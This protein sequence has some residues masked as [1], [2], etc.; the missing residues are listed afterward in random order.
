MK[1]LMPLIALLCS[2]T[3][4]AQSLSSSSRDDVALS[5]NP[6]SDIALNAMDD[7]FKVINGQAIDVSAPGVLAND[8]GE[9]LTSVL[10]QP[11]PE[12]DP[13]YQPLGSLTLFKDGGLHYEPLPGFVGVDTFI[14][15]ITDADGNNSKA[16]IS[17]YCFSE[18]MDVPIFAANDDEFKVL[19]CGAIEVSA[20]GVL[21]NDIGS[22]L[23]VALMDPTQYGEDVVAPQGTL[24]LN[25]DGSF[26]YA[27][28]AGF[29]GVDTFYLIV[30]DEAGNAAKSMVSFYCFTEGS[31]ILAADP[32]SMGEPAGDD[33]G[34]CSAAA[35]AAPWMLLPMIGLALMKLRRARA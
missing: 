24:T 9:N 32:Q 8:S 29:E 30:T 35:G 2:A 33:A 16:A 28:L 5:A 10:Y 4:T 3:I 18:S 7:D 11:A 22:G 20:P 1:Y 13:D 19:N 25:A 17:F 27:P 14:Y 12:D 31:D 34:S 23:T 15:F 6:R 21:A 26:S